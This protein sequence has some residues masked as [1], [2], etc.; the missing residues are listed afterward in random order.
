MSQSWILIDFNRSINNL[1][2]K[3]DMICHASK[4]AMIVTKTSMVCG[5]LRLFFVALAF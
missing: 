2:M 3:I 4:F 1:K 5:S